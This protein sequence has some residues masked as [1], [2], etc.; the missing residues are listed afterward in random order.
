[1]YCWSEKKGRRESRVEKH[2]AED[3]T[4]DMDVEG[5]PCQS[6]LQWWQET[7]ERTSRPFKFW[8]ESWCGYRLWAIVPSSHLSCAAQLFLIQRTECALISTACLW[9]S[10]FCSKPLAQVSLP[11]GV[12]SGPLLNNYQHVFT[13]QKYPFTLQIHRSLSIV[14]SLHTAW[15]TFNGL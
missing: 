7:W 10:C 8:R 1:M 11:F 5:T 4:N 14:N 2:R 12:K 3:C 9:K 13:M 15:N 6:G